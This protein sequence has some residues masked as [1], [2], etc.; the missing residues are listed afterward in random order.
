VKKNKQESVT[1]LPSD[2]TEQGRM[3]G[4]DGA[5]VDNNA[6]V[7]DD[8][9]DDIC[10]VE[11]MQQQVA[12]D[13]F[14]R[15]TGY[16]VAKHRRHELRKKMFSFTSPRERTAYK[17]IIVPYDSDDESCAELDQVNEDSTDKRVHIA[18]PEP[19]KSRKRPQNE[20]GC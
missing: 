5:T 1:L 20:S 7:S 19:R 3:E 12:R 14:R 18:E 10:S 9:D 16:T 17:R 6:A 8:I 2:D 15:T 13:Q 11:G 4:V